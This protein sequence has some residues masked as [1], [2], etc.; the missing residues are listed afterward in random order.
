MYTNESYNHPQKR[1]DDRHFSAAACYHG[2]SVMIALA[3]LYSA[4]FLVEESGLET[5]RL[6]RLQCVV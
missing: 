3:Y 2:Q 4:P 5:Q 1:L 6:T